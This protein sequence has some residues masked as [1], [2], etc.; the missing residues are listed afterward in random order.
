LNYIKLKV[1]A[2]IVKKALCLA[3]RHWLDLIAFAMLDIKSFNLF[4]F[5]VA[6]AQRISSVEIIEA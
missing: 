1:L 6:L 4:H 3:L 2:K 5:R